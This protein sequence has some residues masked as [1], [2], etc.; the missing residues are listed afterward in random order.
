MV[1]LHHLFA[2][3]IDIVRPWSSTHVQIEA[4]ANRRVLLHIHSYGCKLVAQ[5]L[6]RR[7]SGVVKVP[8]GCWYLV[9]LSLFV[10]V[11]HL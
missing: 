1:S 11:P 6:G 9:L 3:L 4:E 7:E 2:S 5:N 10:L 8:L